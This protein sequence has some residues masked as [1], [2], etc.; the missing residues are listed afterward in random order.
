VALFHAGRYEFADTLL[1]RLGAPEAAPPEDPVRSAWIT[2]AHAIR[3]AYQ[4]DNA[5]SLRWMEESA[6]HFERA[7]DLRTA[8]QQWGNVGYL[9]RE[10]GLFEEGAEALRAVL[11]IAERMGLHHIIPTVK[12]NLG[13]TLAWL[14]EPDEGALLE[15]EAARVFEA[16]GDRRFEGASRIYLARIHLLRNDP[17]AAEP[18]ARAAIRVLEHTPQARAFAQAVLAEILARL[19]R[20]EEGLAEARRG[21]AILAEVGGTDEGETFIHLVAA[22]AMIAAGETAEA[23]RIL[24]DARDRLLARAGA[25]GEPDWRDSFLHRIQENRRLL[26][27]A[28]EWL[29]AE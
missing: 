27:L 16:Q 20:P 6:R 4:G 3:S 15:A 21:L 26:E 8:C 25:V 23:L 9:K 7:G 10:L 1:G 18:E 17:D 13:L 29:P 11:G 19:D 5:R 14:G 12:H 22:E 28:T 24:R 2:R